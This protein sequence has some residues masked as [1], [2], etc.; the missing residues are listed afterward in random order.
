[1]VLG[2]MRNRRHI[3]VSGIKNERLRAEGGQRGK[4]RED[5]SNVCF[6]PRPSSSK[7]M[8]MQALLTP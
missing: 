3:G 8:Y 7:S 1:V 6:D 2:Q 4:M 5:H